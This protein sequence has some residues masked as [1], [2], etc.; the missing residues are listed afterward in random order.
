MGR[1][2]CRIFYFLS[3]WY[4]IGKQRSPAELGGMKAGPSKWPRNHDLPMIA[5]LYGPEEWLPV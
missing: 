5:G 2:S 1:L 4:I 3:D